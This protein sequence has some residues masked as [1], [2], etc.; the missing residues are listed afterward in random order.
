MRNET[1]NKEIYE[2]HQG[3]KPGVIIT[4]VKTEGSGPSKTGAKMIVYPEERKS[5]SQSSQ[6]GSSRKDAK[7]Q[8]V[9]KVKNKILGTVG[10]GT[11]ERM[12]IA[13]AKKI[14]ETKKNELVKYNLDDEADGQKTNM[15]CGGNATLFYEY[16]A[17]K[18]YIYIFGAGHIGKELVYHFKNLDYFV[19]L[20][21]DRKD[22]LGKIEGADNKI[23]GKFKDV[24]SN[25]EV[26]PNSYFIIATYEHNYDS[27]VL[28]KIYKSNW[29]PKY[30][31]MVS[32][33]S[34]KKIIF[35]KL[36][37]EVDNPDLSY[38]YLPVGIDIG[39]A[40][41]PEIAISIVSEIQAIR[42]GKDVKH[43]RDK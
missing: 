40:S 13:K 28:N 22:V 29:N 6:K 36:K 3:R 16:F 1:L 4:V 5:F 35:D 2:L 10:G 7:T 25:Q 17:T 23:F 26:S 42:Y 12:A 27:L 30:I 37:S 19:T 8:R 41:P 9:N 31:G 38:C 39:G 11:I 33:R 18:N 24:L 34:K 14:F 20:I 43:L 32:S 15:I 21:D